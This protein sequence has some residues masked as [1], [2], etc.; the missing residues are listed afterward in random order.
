MQNKNN[1]DKILLQ[2]FKQAADEKLGNELGPYMMAKSHVAV[3]TGDVV[4]SSVIFFLFFFFFSR[5]TAVP[6]EN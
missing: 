3:K 5:L 1:R 4:Q 2:K 6:S